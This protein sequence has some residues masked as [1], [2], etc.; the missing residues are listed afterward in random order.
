MRGRGRRRRRAE[1]AMRSAEREDG[2]QGHAELEPVFRGLASGARAQRGAEA[3]A[4]QLPEDAAAQQELV[5]AA[6]IAASEE[7][8]RLKPA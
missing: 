5:W 1:S 6:R 4:E 7:A 2:R 8:E 3:A